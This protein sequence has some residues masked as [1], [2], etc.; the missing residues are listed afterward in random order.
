M[1]QETLPFLDNA[2]SAH[3]APS[4]QRV[5]RSGAQITFWETAV[6]I[7][8]KVSPLKVDFLRDLQFKRVNLKCRL[9][10]DISVPNF[11]A[12][13][14]DEPCHRHPPAPQ[15]PRETS[16]NFLCSFPNSRRRYHP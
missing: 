13:E 9:R 11:G 10:S 4:A 1:Y 8:V 14:S 5:F 16:Y 7:T 2:S 12:F 15:E 6:K 3:D